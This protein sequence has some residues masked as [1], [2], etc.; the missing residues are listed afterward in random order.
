VERYLEHQAGKL[1]ARFDAN[2]YL[3]LT[4]AME[5][6]DPFAEPSGDLVAADPDVSV[7]S[8]QSDRLFGS[9]HSRFIAERLMKAGT[10]C[11][12][13]HEES[14]RHGHDAFLTGVPAYL[15]AMR[16]W[17]GTRARPRPAGS[18]PTANT[19]KSA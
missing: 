13:F 7:I 4:S 14:S 8:F 19:R 12:R 11:T 18:G 15:D 9:D 6:F 3:C 10:R 16:Q 2:S 5:R 17:L 1:T